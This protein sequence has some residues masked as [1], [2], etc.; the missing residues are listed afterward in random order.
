M[1]ASGQTIKEISAEL[2]LSEKTI[3]TYRARIAKK[4]GLN[5]NVELTRYAMQHQLVD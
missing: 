4:L 2:A 1:V 5:S 3:G